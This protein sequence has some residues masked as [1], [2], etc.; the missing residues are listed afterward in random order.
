MLDHGAGDSAQEDVLSHPGI[1]CPASFQTEAG[2]TS[3]QGTG[4]AGGGKQAGPQPQCTQIM[5]DRQS[6]L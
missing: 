5:G 3:N 4:G 2:A 1:G 6:Q